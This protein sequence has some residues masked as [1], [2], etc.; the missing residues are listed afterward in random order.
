MTFKIKTTAIVCAIAAFVNFTTPG[1]AFAVWCQADAP[2]VYMNMLTS[3][4]PF[5]SKL[6]GGTGLSIEESVTQSGAGVR[7]EVAKAAMANKAVAEGIESYEQQE[8]L[9]R[10]TADLKDAMAQPAQTCEAMAT[11]ESLSSATIATQK[12]T[13]SS[14]GALMSKIAVASN[15]NTFA[16]LDAAHKASNARFCTAEEA[17][18]GICTVA[19]GEFAK[20]A[21]AD[22][23]AAYLFQGNDGSSSFD[24]AAQV[25]A[26]DAYIERVVGG[27]PAQ[28]LDQRGEEFYRKNPQARVF[29]ELARRYG[30]MQS[31]AAYSLNSSKEAHRTQPGLGTSSMMADVDA[32]G[33]TA[34]KADMSMAEVVERFVASKFSPKNVMDLMKAPKP[35]LILRDMAQMNN[36]QLYMS[37]QA[38]LQSSRVEAL[39]AHQLSLIAE[40]ALRPQLNAQRVQAAKANAVAR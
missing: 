15:A 3:F 30:A 33:F 1:K 28:A 26:A 20:L 6:I 11:S 5:V 10:D 19:G 39:Q 24:G 2:M 23:D 37:Y 17:A 40:Q 32:P 7:A 12:A 31:M 35:N 8:Q 25:Q 13:M 36:F 4:M 21:G 9:R 29:A 16:A 27:L 14:Q 38:M 34:G 22:R 18:Q